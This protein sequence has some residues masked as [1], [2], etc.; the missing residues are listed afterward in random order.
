[1]RNLVKTF[2][3]VG[4]LVITLLVVSVIIHIFVFTGL[5]SDI[6]DI[7]FIRVSEYARDI[8]STTGVILL[9][10]GGIIAILSHRSIRAAIQDGEIKYVIKTGVFRFVRHPL[11]LSVM[12]MSLSL[13]LLINSY[14]L[15]LT[16]FIVI[17]VLVCEAKWEEGILTKKFGDEYMEYKRVTGMFLPKIL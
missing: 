6:L 8:S 12:M 1:M 11:Y 5:D 9:I 10:V 16:F 7:G 4:N 15:L 2:G 13:A 3:N 17:V 14:L